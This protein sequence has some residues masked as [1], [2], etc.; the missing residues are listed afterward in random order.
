[1]SDTD[2]LLDDYNHAAQQWGS[3]GSPRRT[4]YEEAETKIHEA[5]AEFQLPNH[6][7]YSGASPNYG[8]KCS[9]CHSLPCQCVAGIQRDSDWEGGRTR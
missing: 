1:M 4:P 7:K 3:A 6:P 5:L 2:Q 8:K 9:T